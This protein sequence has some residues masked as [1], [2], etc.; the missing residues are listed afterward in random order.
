MTVHA[1]MHAITRRAAA[2]VHEIYYLHGDGSSMPIAGS[3]LRMRE[4]HLPLPPP[5]YRLDGYGL[6]VVGAR[7]A[8]GPAGRSWERRLYLRV[9]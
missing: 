9:L 5:A 7:R 6:L 4:A 2:G 1:I 3:D 8:P